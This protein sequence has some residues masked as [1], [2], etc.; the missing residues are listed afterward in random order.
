MNDLLDSLVGNLTC[1]LYNTKSKNFWKLKIGKDSKKCGKYNH[2]ET[3]KY[4]KLV[5]ISAKFMKTVNYW[6]YGSKKKT[7]LFQVLKILKKNKEKVAIA[8]TKISWPI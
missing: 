3:V 1:N 5:N 2:D 7:L 8:Y 6:I 4:I